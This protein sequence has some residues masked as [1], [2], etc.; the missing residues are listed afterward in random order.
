MSRG[1]IPAR[2]RWTQVT[3]DITAASTFSE[4]DAL[5]IS[6]LGQ[7]SLYSGGQGNFIGIA[8]HASSASL[9]AGKVVMEVPAGPGCTVMVN[10]PT[11]LAASS[12]SFGETFGIYAVGGSTSFLTKS[13]TSTSGRPFTVVGSCVLSPTSRIEAAIKY[14]AV[15]YGSALSSLLV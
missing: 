1:L 8:T 10:V 2:G 13:Y 15:V 5:G 9:P 14:D 3:W 7:V 6:T 4:G 12:F 11:G